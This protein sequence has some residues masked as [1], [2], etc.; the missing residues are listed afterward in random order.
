MTHDKKIHYMQ[1]AVGM[2]NFGIHDRDLDLLVS[3]YEL[4][5]KMEGGTTMHDALDV[6]EQVKERWIKKAAEE[7]EKRK[8]K[9]AATAQ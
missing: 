8:S 9:A 3:M 4:I 2:C 5:I 7:E 6:K 1:L